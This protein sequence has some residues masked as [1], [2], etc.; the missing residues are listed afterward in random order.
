[1]D[2]TSQ[3]IELLLSV[4]RDGPQTLGAQIEEQLRSAIRER[5]HEARLPSPGRQP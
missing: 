4:T 5:A 1:L 3:P 2:E